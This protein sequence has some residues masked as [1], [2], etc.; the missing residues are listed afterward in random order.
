MNIMSAM[1]TVNFWFIV[2]LCLVSLIIGL[3]V[4]ASRRGSGQSDR[5][6]RY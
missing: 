4:G 1:V 2:T 5:H 3:L 6:L